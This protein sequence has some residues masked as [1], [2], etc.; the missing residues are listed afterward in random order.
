MNKIGPR[1]EPRGTP[2]RGPML[3]SPMSTYVKIRRRQ[4]EGNIHR[5]FSR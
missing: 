3:K 2:C 1:T 4:R 5:I